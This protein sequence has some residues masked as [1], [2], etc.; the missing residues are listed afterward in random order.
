ML[1]WKDIIKNW[2]TVLK[3]DRKS[4]IRS[5]K[6]GVPA[7]Y[8]KYVWPLLTDA[9]KVKEKSEFDYQS[10]LKKSES[11]RII[12][13]DVPRTFPN[14]PSFTEELRKSLRNV[15]VAYSNADPEVGYY[16]GMNF[17]AGLFLYYMDEE[18]TFWSFYS[19]MQRSHR[20]FFINR[21]QHFHE[22]SPLIEYL[23]EEKFPSISKLLKKQKISPILYTPVWFI[24]CYIGSDLD[25]KMISFI[26]DQYLAFGEVI[27]VSF[28]MTVISINKIIAE[29]Q[30]FD[31][32]LSCLI[33]PGRSDMM[34]NQVV[35]NLE[36]VNQWITCSKYEKFCDI[37]LKKTQE[38]D[39]T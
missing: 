35:V 13:C 17:V 1:K 32:F 22:I 11:E 8:R 7:K 36:W 2:D 18:I 31:E 29:T 33:N 24:T 15:L 39:H 16:Q 5:L 3:T 38:L 4:I 30:P 37:Y 23:V 20:N 10:L 28:G 34:H 6:L 14:D 25:F 21:F 27:L 19:L 12:D 9:K 26:F